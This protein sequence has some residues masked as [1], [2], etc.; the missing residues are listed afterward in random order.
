MR[1]WKSLSGRTKNLVQV[2]AAVLLWGVT[3]QFAKGLKLPIVNIMCI[4]SLIGAA[5][6]LAFLLITKEKI[7]IKKPKNYRA[8]IAS[9]IL[10]CLHWLTYFKAVRISSV[11][12]GILAL[13]TYPV[14]TT[15]VE[16]FLFK[17]KLKGVDVILAA[18]VFLGI[19]IMA[20]EISLSNKMTQGILL[21]IISGIF[22]LSRNLIMKK[23]VREYSS[24]VLMF[25]QTLAAGIILVP[26][27]FTSESQYS[28]KTWNLL[29]LLGVVFTALSHTLFAAGFKHL[30]T[31]TVSIIATLLPFYGTFIAYFVHNE[32]VA[33]KTFIGGIIILSVVLFETVKSVRE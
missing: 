29:I 18:I 26:F 8:M 31:K 32:T 6:L 3:V 15:L 21:G 1:F 28:L 30:S 22:F 20:P 33:S 14:I 12:V 13:H 11:A 10:L 2:N 25:Y 4:R 19:A 24:S 5:A 17:K 7:K 9:G 23:Y 16:P 27:M